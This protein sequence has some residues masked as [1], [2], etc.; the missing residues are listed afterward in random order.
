MSADGVTGAILPSIARLVQWLGY[1]VGVIKMCG[2]SLARPKWAYN[3]R[4][5]RRGKVLTD[6]N[7][8]F[9]KEDVKTLSK[10]EILQKSRTRLRTTSISGKSKTGSSSKADITPRDLKD[11]CIIAPS[12]VVN[13]R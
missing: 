4:M 1:P 5:I 2:A 6:C 13:L 7:M 8:L 9:T 3:L 10:E 11:F 12:V